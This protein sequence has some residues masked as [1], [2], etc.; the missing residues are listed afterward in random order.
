MLQL[1]ERTRAIQANNQIIELFQYFFENRRDAVADLDLPAGHE[2]NHLGSIVHGDLEV[3]LDLL[4]QHDLEVKLQFPSVVLARAL[5]SKY[6]RDVELTIL[7]AANQEFCY[8]IFCVTNGALSEA[9]IREEIPTSFHI[10]FLARDGSPLSL[11][12]PW[13]PRESGVNPHEGSAMAY[14]FNGRTKV[15]LITFPTAK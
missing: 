3:A 5:S 6:R 1:H 12:A 13:L 15:E 14:F 4:K 9:E 7:K 8:E 2:L 10:A 11:P